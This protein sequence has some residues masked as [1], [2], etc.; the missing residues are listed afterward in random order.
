M[1]T[2]VESPRSGGQRYPHKDKGKGRTHRLILRKVRAALEEIPSPSRVR[3]V[4]VGISGG[5]DSGVLLHLLADIRT[6]GGPALAAAHVHHGIRGAEA[7]RDARIAE[8]VATGHGVE[9]HVVR[10]RPPKGSRTPEHVLRELRLAALE[11]TARRIGADRIVLAHHRDDQAETLL[12][13]LFT[14]TDLR[15]LASIRPY[16]APLWVRPLLDVSRAEIERE[17][18]LCHIPYGTDSTNLSTRPRRNFLRRRL[19]PILRAEF[20]PRISQHLSA[21]AESISKVNDLLEC[22]AAAALRKALVGRGR[23]DVTRLRAL[24]DALRFVALQ[25]AYR[26]EAGEGSALRRVQLRTVDSLVRTD[27]RE[28]FFKLPKGVSVRRAKK[29]I[30]FGRND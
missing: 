3:K 29:W 19:L 2:S 18:E 9:F 30:R 7:D 28:R 20:N 11:R 24:P 22:Q 6:D 26:A 13:R 8:R 10:I 16:R 25:L 17:A 14:G 21:L 27:G 4:L 23:Y 5:V 1:E 12:L 15:G